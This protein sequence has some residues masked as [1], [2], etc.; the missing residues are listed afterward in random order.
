LVYSVD[1]TVLGLVEETWYPVV[2]AI[3]FSLY[4]YPRQSITERERESGMNGECI[5]DEAHLARSTFASTSGGEILCEIEA[6]ATHDGM[7]M[8]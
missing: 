1:R 2:G 5:P 6:R 7:K 3:L 4:G 8:T